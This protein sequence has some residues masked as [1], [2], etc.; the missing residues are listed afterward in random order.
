LLIVEDEVSVPVGIATYL[1]F[2]IGS[3]RVQTL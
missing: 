2:R 3:V 1:A